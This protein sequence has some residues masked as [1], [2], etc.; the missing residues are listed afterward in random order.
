METLTDVTNLSEDH[1]RLTLDAVMCPICLDVMCFPVTMACNHEM[2]KECYDFHFE[3]ANFS[4]PMCKRRLGSWARKAALQ[5]KLINLKKWNQIQE[6]YPDLI[7]NKNSIIGND[8]V[9][10]NFTSP[11][12][13]AA[14]GEVN[15]E[16][17]ESLEKHIK[18]R[19]EQRKREEE[20]SLRF[21]QQLQKQE[22]DEK[23]QIKI[24]KDEDVAKTLS[25]KLHVE[26]SPSK[27]NRMVLRTKRKKK[28]SNQNN[29]ENP[30][31]K[32]G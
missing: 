7:Q 10:Q 19:E 31:K 32:K 16:Y 12:K 1:Q 9:F 26:Y 14:P 24:K 18:E 11:H 23:I 17:V 21:I 22:E 2:C 27:V 4:C 20:E 29:S 6:Q 30:S 25:E 15:K 5:G 28:H 3:K 8:K 13:L